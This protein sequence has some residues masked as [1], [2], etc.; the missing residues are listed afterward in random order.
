VR[1]QT[2]DLSGPL[3]KHGRDFLYVRIALDIAGRCVSEDSVFLTQHRFVRLPGKAK[4]AATVRLADSRRGTIAFRSSAFQH[5][6]MFDF[7]GVA[8][9]ASDNYFELFP[10]EEKTVAVEFERPQTAARLKRLLTH[11]SLA[12]SY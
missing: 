8:F 6:F 9:R 10:G 5:R 11:M 3:A 4:T 12:G 1:Q 7:P 2:L